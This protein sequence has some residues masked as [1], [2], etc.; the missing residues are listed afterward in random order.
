MKDPRKDWYYHPKY[1]LVRKDPQGYY[2][3]DTETYISSESNLESVYER[4][5]RLFV[6]QA[7]MTELTK[8]V[9]TSPDWNV[10]ALT[11]YYM[12]VYNVIQNTI[13]NNGK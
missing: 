9:E 13:K 2:E 6:E 8:A 3:G 11:N 4:D 5:Q 1:G 7:V 12:R 10:E